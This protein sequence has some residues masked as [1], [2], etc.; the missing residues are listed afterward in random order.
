MLFV[1]IDAGSALAPVAEEDAPGVGVGAAEASTAD[2]EASSA[3]PSAAAAAATAVVTAKGTSE[4]RADSKRIISAVDDF[5]A[6]AKQLLGKLAAQHPSEKEQAVFLI[7]NY[8]MLCGLFEEMNIH[9]ATCFERQCVALVS[10]LA[11][12]FFVSPFFFSSF[13]WFR[14]VSLLSM[15]V[16]QRARVQHTAACPAPIP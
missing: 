1:Q 13:F 5:L 7:N 11:A 4:R 3:A 8:D 12:Y 9:S 15:A 10:R 14:C 16:L 6:V 2:C